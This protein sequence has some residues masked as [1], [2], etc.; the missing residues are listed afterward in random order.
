MAASITRKV[1]T[2]QLSVAA[3]ADVLRDDEIPRG[4]GHEPLL[5]TLVSH[6]APGLQDAVLTLGEQ[7]LAQPP[8]VVAEAPAS[9]ASVLRCPRRQIGVGLAC[10]CTGRRLWHGQ[11]QPGTGEPEDPDAVRGAAILA[12]FRAAWARLI[13]RVGALSPRLL[14]L[15]CPRPSW[16]AVPLR[17]GRCCLASREF[18]LGFMVFSS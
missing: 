13:Q 17:S 18:M 6:P 4:T 11:A 8:Q 3:F 1:S 9:L 2:A 5:V 15:R 16:F 14:G 12:W 7:F 10:H